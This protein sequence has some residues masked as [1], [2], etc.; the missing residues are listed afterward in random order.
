MALLLAY[1][2]QFA[3]FAGM[4]W[5]GWS[6]RCNEWTARDKHELIREAFSRPDWEPLSELSSRVSYDDHFRAYQMRRD[7]WALYHPFVRALVRP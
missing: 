4:A 2:V 3:C 1:F 5:C 6:L 7:P